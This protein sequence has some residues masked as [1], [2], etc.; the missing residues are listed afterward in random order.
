MRPGALVILIVAVSHPAL[1]AQ[2]LRLA[3]SIQDSASGGIFQSGF[4]AAFRSLGDV[5]VV[6][7]TERP[8]YVL[9]GVVLCSPQPCERAVS[10]SIALRLHE[11]IQK[12]T[13]EFLADYAVNPKGTRAENPFVQIAN[14]ARRDSLVSLIWSFISEYERTQITWAAEWGRSAYE[15]GIREL[16]AEIDAKCLDKLRASRRILPASG[17]GTPAER[18]ARYQEFVQSREW[19]C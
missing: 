5:D 7:R 4:A 8:D 13:A 3:V 12:S 6:T 19:I 11:P 14:E 17:E 2:R 9:S 10:Y 18:W 16:V 1:E 15:R